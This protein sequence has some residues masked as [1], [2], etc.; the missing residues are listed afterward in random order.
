MEHSNKGKVTLLKFPGET[1]W[2]EITAEFNALVQ[3]GA[4]RFVFNI[5]RLAVIDSLGIAFFLESLEWL[6]ESHGEIVLSQPS[7]AVRRSR[8]ADDGINRA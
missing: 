7:G 6:Q 5:H 1:R 4:T 3:Q 2:P 8:Q